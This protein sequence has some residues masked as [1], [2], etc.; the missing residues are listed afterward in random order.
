M[1]CKKIL[2]HWVRMVCLPSYQALFVTVKKR[3]SSRKRGCL[4]ESYIFSA[5]AKY[6]AAL[7]DAGTDPDKFSARL[8]MLY[9]HARFQ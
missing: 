9:H 2:S 6:I 3:H 7:V 8:A 4:R 5:H 1:S